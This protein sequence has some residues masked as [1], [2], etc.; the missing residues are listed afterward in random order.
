M[1]IEIE[2]GLENAAKVEPSTEEMELSIEPKGL[3]HAKTRRLLFMGGLVV[4][5]ALVALY[6]YYRKRES[7]DDAQ[8][9]GHIT[10]I[11]SKVYGRVAE[12]LVDDNQQVKAGQ[13]LARLDPR[14]YQ[15]ALDQAKARS[16][17]ERRPVG[18][19][20]R[21]ENG[22]QRPERHQQR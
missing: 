20:G 11:S 18:R 9:D 10:Q 2:V 13:V 22:T 21:A 14:D 8:V 7:T 19:R 4:L 16:R 3:A 15:A 12:V 6:L 1:S 5:A 17:R